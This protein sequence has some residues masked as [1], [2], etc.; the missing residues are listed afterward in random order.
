MELTQKDLTELIHYDPISGLFSW[1][2]VRRGVVVGKSLGTDNGFGYLRITVLG[3]SYYAHRLAWMYVHGA[4]PDCQIDHINGNRGDN[5]LGNLRAA[6]SA[7]NVQNKTKA[8]SNSASGVLGVSWHKHGKK[9]QSHIAKDGKRLFLGLFETID[10][11]QQAY[12]SAK[13]RIHEFNTL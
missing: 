9:W 13:R 12:L 11:A 2:K 5:R 4:F 10:A 1:S 3:R 8:Q 7:E 6:T